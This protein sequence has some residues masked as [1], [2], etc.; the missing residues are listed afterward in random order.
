[1]RV[2]PRGATPI[3]FAYAIH[4]QLGD[5]VTGARINGKIEPLRYKLRNGDVVEVLTH[6]QPAP[7]QGLARLRR[8]RRG[9]RSKIRNYLRARAARQDAS[10]SGEEL[11]ERELHKARRS[12][13]A[14]SSR[15]TREMRRVFETLKVQNLEELLRRHRLRQDRSRG[16]RSRSSRRPTRRGARASRPSSCARGASR[17]SS[18]RSS[19]ATRAR[20][21]STGST[22]CSSATPSAATRC[23]GDDIL[24]FITRGRGVTIHRRGLSEGVRHRPRAARRDHA[25]TRKAQHQPAACSSA[26]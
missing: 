16:G 11:L 18:A 15:T 25:G 2:F 24:G 9:A 26:W 10:A 1:M 7:E 13:R 14:S 12:A 8:A 5:H 22:T 19:S 21:A 23:P 20:S 6:A 3:D 17:A 4:T